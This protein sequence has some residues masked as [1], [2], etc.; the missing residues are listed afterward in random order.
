MMFPQAPGYSQ[1]VRDPVDLETI[2]DR[3]REQSRVGSETLYYRTKA[4]LRAD[5]MRMVR[6]C[7]SMV[8]CV[9]V[10]YAMVCDGVLLCS[11]RHRVSCRS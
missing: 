9:M 8:F 11:V 7:C 3:L 5:L 1:I 2:S 4:M 6:P 10:C